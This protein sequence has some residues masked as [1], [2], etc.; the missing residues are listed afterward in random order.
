MVAAILYRWRG[1]GIQ[2]EA[3]ALHI[4][5]QPVWEWDI[6]V[7]LL[8]ID[9]AQRPGNQDVPA[10]RRSAHYFRA[11]RALAACVPFD[12]PDR[13]NYAHDQPEEWSDD[14][15]RSKHRHTSFFELRR[16]FSVDLALRTDWPLNAPFVW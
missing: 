15:M 3:S 2:G 12:I 14:R 9:E 1:Y 11:P 4:P 16:V 13:G 8:A 7:Q 6:Q 5:F 10:L